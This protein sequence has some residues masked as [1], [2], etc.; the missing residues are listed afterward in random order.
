MEFRR[1]GILFG[2]R[3]KVPPKIYDGGITRVPVVNQSAR[4][5]GSSS[6]M[7]QRALVQDD[8]VAI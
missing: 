8:N 7:G 3:I 1:L 2:V 6:L 5:D 4:E